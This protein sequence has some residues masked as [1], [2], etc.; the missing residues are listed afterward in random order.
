MP[1]DND[2]SVFKRAGLPGLNFAYIDGLSNYHTA[3]DNLSGLDLRS[4]QH[5]GSYA[6]A[7]ARHFGDL[8]IGQNRTSDQTY[9]SVIG[10]IF[11]RYSTA[12]A[13]ILAA[14]DC[15]LF[16]FVAAIGFKRRLISTRGILMG[17]AAFVVSL[18]ICSGA[19]AAVWQLL[20]L[21][22]GQFRLLPNRTPY[23][24]DLFILGFVALT[25]AIMTSLLAFLSKKIGA[26]SLNLGT[27]FGWLILTV[28]VTLVAPTASYPFAWPLFFSLVSAAVLLKEQ[29]R[30]STSLARVAVISALAVPGIILFVPII[31]LLA[32]SMGLEMV[33]AVA[34]CEVLLLSLLI[35]H[36][37]VLVRSRK[38][39]LPGIA[40]ILAV[41]FLVT[42][43]ITP[44]V[45]RHHPKADSIFYALNAESGKAVWAS[46]DERS[47]EWTSQ[48]LGAA[49]TRG[50]LSE[51]F[52]TNTATYLRNEAP[53]ITLKP[54]TLS[55][56]ADTTQNGVRTLHLRLASMRQAAIIAASLDPASGS[57]TRVNGKQVN[58]SLDNGWGIRYYG[59]GNDGIDFV[60][61]LNSSDPIKIKI[62]DMTYQLPE[63]ESLNLKP[64]PEHIIPAPLALSDS[65]LV[66][67]SFVF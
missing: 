38:W 33:W 54:P 12:V 30:T 26:Q 27:L 7:L 21:L 41:G 50:I 2:L 52:A 19:V 23:S 48:F 5:H 8:S 34:A 6:L 59:A 56:L 45:D 49:A 25:L 1:N 10:P 55:V 65:T 18:G 42:A 22:N 47:D 9:F 35:P 67:Y 57:V 4:L 66:S 43:S 14:G 51:Y 36:I 3:A 20:K 64:R 24:S 39:L 31:Y 58:A 28:V 32:I 44:G 16:L 15:L 46:Y 29:E 40:A 13:L 37:L 53:V 60:L 11:V 61:E 17:L 63:L 62:L